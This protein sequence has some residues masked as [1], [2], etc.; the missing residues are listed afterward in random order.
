[1]PQEPPKKHQEEYRYASVQQ[2]QQ[3]H[4]PTTEEYRHAS[5]AAAAAQQ[6]EEQIPKAIMMAE[7]KQEDQHQQQHVT[8]SHD[9]THPKEHEQPPLSKSKSRRDSDTP[10]KIERYL[11]EDA[12]DLVRPVDIAKVLNLDRHNTA[13]ALSK[14]VKQGLV[15]QPV[16]GMYRHKD[17]SKV[18]Q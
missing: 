9:R 7:Q 6:K 15:I 10:T 17:N 1:M 4:Q 18:K 16:K 12:T 8:V 3:H 14:L 11:R 2:Q 5:I 13:Y